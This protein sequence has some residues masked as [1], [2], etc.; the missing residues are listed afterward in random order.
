MDELIL[1]RHGEAEHHIKGLTGGWTDSDLTELGRQQ[2]ELTG[3]FL[4][5]FCNTKKVGLFSSPL[6]RAKETAEIFSK[7]LHLKP[8][9]ADALKEL[10]WG[11][12]TNMTLEEAE[13]YQLPQTK[14][15]RDWKPFPE[16]ESWQMLY[17]RVCGYMTKLQ[18]AAY[19]LFIIV[20]HGNALCTIISWWLE[21]PESI[22]S[23][24]DFDLEPC[25]FT[26]LRVNDWQQKTLS[27]LNS[28]KHLAPLEARI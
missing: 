8:V 25:S 6:S 18:N 12:V 7:I 22:Q 17:D 15:R 23:K 27:V 4:L 13:Q 2:A 11:I 10:Y 24:I 14:P 16:A 28:T 26:Y 1:I 5:P 21:I 9:F 19:D 20:S 3:Q